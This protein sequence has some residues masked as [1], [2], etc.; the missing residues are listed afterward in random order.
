MG[1]NRYKDKWKRE[2]D[3]ERDRNK[4]MGHKT[5]SVKSHRQW[6]RV[7]GRKGKQKEGDWDKKTKKTNLQSL[8]PSD[9]MFPQS[10]TQ[11]VKISSSCW[12][13]SETEKNH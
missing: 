12:E 1:V 6:D 10:L 7:Q 4:E 9:H 2:R 5:K 11:K 13:K 3:K 8:A